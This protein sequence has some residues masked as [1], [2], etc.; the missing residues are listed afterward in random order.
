MAKVKKS[1]VVDDL[2]ECYFCGRPATETHHIL[3]GTANRKI[4]DRYGLVVGLCKNHHTGDNGVHFNPQMD[5][6]LKQK[7]QRAFIEKYSIE[8]WMKEIG[9]NY[10][11]ED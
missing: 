8:L 9:R 4:A 11:Q 2:S 5:L 1:I 7:A 3:H 10:L 6:H